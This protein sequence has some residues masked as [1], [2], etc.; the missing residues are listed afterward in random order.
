MQNRRAA[1]YT[2]KECSRYSENGNSV[3]SKV[4]IIIE[5]KHERDT[6]TRRELKVGRVRGSS[7][8]H[9]S[10]FPHSFSSQFFVG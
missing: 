6:K 2:C 8:A 1:V 10:Q 3:D 9:F 5:R 4:S 7:F